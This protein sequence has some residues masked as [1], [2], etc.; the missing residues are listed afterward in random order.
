MNKINPF[1]LALVLMP[2][3]GLAKNYDA[4]CSNPPSTHAKLLCKKISRNKQ[5]YRNYAPKSSASSSQSAVT[6]TQSFKEERI[7]KRK[8]EKQSINSNTQID[9]SASQFEFKPYTRGAYTKK[10]TG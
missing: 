1:I 4:F 2:I 8:H 10:Q 7:E 3:V 9:T 5:N 6:P